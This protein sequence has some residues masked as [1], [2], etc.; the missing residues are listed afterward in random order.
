MNNEEIIKELGLNPIKVTG[1]KLMK[2]IQENGADSLAEDLNTIKEE[3]EENLDDMLNEARTD[4]TKEIFKELDEIAE[5]EHGMDLESVLLEELH[6]DI[7]SRKKYEALKK[8][9]GII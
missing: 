2:I 1:K 3:V 4:T 7:E 8:K 6:R 9:Y 5:M